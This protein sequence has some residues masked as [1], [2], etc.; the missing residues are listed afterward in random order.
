[1][2]GSTKEIIPTRNFILEIVEWVS[3]TPSVTKK[4]PFSLPRSPLWRRLKREPDITFS[5]FS[6]EISAF[7]KKVKLSK[8]FYIKFSIKIVLIKICVACVLTKLQRLK[9]RGNVKKIYTFILTVH[10]PLVQPA[11]H[12]IIQSLHETDSTPEYGLL[13]GQFYQLA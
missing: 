9:S 6:R 13:I 8:I 2:Y 12:I 4:K 11:E 3:M 5:R 1:M 7:E 10:M